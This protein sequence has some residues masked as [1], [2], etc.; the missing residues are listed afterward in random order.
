ME[1]CGSHGKNVTEEISAKDV[2]C[3]MAVEVSMI[4]HTRLVR[5]KQKR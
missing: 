3:S 5:K 4:K 1:Q 2:P